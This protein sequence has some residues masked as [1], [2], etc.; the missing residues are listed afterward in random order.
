M[1][2]MEGWVVVRIVTFLRRMAPCWKTNSSIH[3]FEF[4]CAWCR[5]SAIEQSQSLNMMNPAGFG[6][7]NLSFGSDVE[8]S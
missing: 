1:A 8:W 2:R 5:F 7:S 6:C 4:G 3:T